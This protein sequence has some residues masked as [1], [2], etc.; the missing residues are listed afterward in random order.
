MAKF[1]Y[2]FAVLALM[3]VSANAL[4]CYECPLGCEGDDKSKWQ[5]QDCGGASATGQEKVCLKQVIKGTGGKDRVV[6]KCA[7]PAAGKKFE[8]VDAPGEKTTL[9]ETCTTDLCNSAGSVTFS[10]LALASVI[11]PF[12]ATRLH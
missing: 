9:C 2:V 10:F 8:C 6:R 12:L 4:K 5:T 3:A 11:V 7:L 1:V